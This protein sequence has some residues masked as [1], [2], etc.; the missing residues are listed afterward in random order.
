M[1]WDWANGHGSPV[2]NLFFLREA[3]QALSL[4]GIF[5]FSLL[6]ALDLILLVNLRS[7]SNFG[8]NRSVCGSAGDAGGGAA[9]I[10]RASGDGDGVAGGGCT[11][12][13][14]GNPRNRRLLGLTK[15]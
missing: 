3:L 10:G 11:K 1:F 7:S 13:H 8:N 2:S 5:A 14:S 15:D 12:C 6:V 4:P 9:D